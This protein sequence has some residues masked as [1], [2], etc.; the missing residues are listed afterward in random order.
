MA[1]KTAK[2]F[3]RSYLYEYVNVWESIDNKHNAFQGKLFR[4]AC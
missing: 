3:V 2:K 4:K 1:D